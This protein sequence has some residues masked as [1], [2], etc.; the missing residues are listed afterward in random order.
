MFLE[1]ITVVGVVLLVLLLVGVVSAV[2]YSQATCSPE[3]KQVSNS[4]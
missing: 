3:E 4:P 1:V 2:I